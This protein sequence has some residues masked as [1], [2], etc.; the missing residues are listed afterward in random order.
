MYVRARQ[1]NRFREVT[2]FGLIGSELPLLL[3]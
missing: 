3:K 1:T 2:F